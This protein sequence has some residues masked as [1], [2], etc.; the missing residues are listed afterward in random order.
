MTWADSNYTHKKKITISGAKVSGSNTN[1]PILLNFTD[2]DLTSC[3]ANGYDIKFYSSGESLQLKHERQ[4]WNNATGKLITWVKVP[5]ISSNASFSGNTIYMYYEYGSESSDQQDAS[6]VWDANY[7]GVWH[8]T[9]NPAGTEYNFLDST[10]NNHHGSS[11]ADMVEEQS[12]DGKMG[13][14]IKLTGYPDM[15]R[16][17]SGAWLSLSTTDFT[18]EGVFQF[19]TGTT[20]Q[21]VLCRDGYN[22]FLKICDDDSFC[23]YYI[24][25]DYHARTP[26]NTGMNIDTW[27]YGVVRD[28]YST[29]GRSWLNGVSGTTSTTN[30]F[31]G[32]KDTDVDLY[33]GCRGANW[34]R[35][36]SGQVSEIRM[37]DT[38]RTP[39]WIW[40]QYNS[41]MNNSTFMY[42][43]SEESQEATAEWTTN[44]IPIGTELAWT[45]N[46]GQF[47]VDKSMMA[48]SINLIEFTWTDVSSSTTKF[49]RCGNPTSWIWKQGMGN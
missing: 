12:V 33:I 42:F 18:I 48:T 14:G 17:P 37:S 23:P 27:Y 40:T 3:L 1:F 6:N 39:G 45:W 35:Y 8:L 7:I 36:L 10:T 28:D 49:Y 46:S 5:K 29:E 41:M 32:R 38:L 30:F 4:E 21:E 2:G 9:E 11:Q 44:Y 24:D 26:V 43:D 25:S 22:Q 19:N 31:N 15:I 47:N 34:D 16:I 13:K 20:T